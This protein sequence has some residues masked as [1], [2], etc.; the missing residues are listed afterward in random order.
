[1]YLCR[2][3][4]QY[5]MPRIRH[6]TLERL[7]QYISAELTGYETVL[8]LSKLGYSD[9]KVALYNIH[10]A[11][12]LSQGRTSLFTFCCTSLSN[13]S[14]FLS[15]SLYISLSLF[16]YTYIYIYMYQLI[17]LIMMIMH[18]IS[19]CNSLPL[20]FCGEVVHQLLPCFLI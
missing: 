8:E 6:Q 16:I 7:P 10:L 13:L 9:F 17:L 1:M 3:I 18:I 11:P 14:I 12:L 5:S 19:V 2:V 20:L 15:L 4:C